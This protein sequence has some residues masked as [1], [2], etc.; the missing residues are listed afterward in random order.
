MSPQECEKARCSPNHLEM[1]PDSP[2]MAREQS[3]VPYQQ[4]KWLDFL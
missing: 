2:A 4:V 3:S 1:T